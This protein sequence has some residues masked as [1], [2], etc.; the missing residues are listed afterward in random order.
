MA[1][2]EDSH[3]K[4]WDTIGKAIGVRVSAQREECV[5]VHGYASVCTPAMVDVRIS[6]LPA[7]HIEFDNSRTSASITVNGHGVR[8]RDLSLYQQMA[9]KEPWSIGGIGFERLMPR[10]SKAGSSNIGEAQ[11][12]SAGAPADRTN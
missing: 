8:V 9:P 10:P 5:P 6:G 12:R 7:M 2:T 1:Q 3:M 4:F 11:V